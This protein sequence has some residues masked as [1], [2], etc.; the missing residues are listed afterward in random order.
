M[1]CQRAYRS[2]LALPV[3]ENVF[4]MLEGEETGPACACP[5]VA[6]YELYDLP[7][8]GT[9]SDNTATSARGRLPSLDCRGGRCRD[10]EV[11]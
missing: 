2:T 10:S 4:R 1:C 7:G 8:E 5:T 9:T 11:R 6:L 3:N